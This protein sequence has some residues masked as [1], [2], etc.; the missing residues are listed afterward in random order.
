MGGSAKRRIGG[1]AI[2][3]LVIAGVVAVTSPSASG[4]TAPEA[5]GPVL[6]DYGTLTIGLNNATGQYKVV[7]DPTAAAANVE[8]V[9][10]ATQPCATVTPGVGS[11]L[12]F[13]PNQGSLSDTVQIRNNAF[14]VNTGNTSC[15][16]SAAAV[17]SG[18]ELLKI[19][20]GSALTG[21][22]APVQ[23][24]AKSAALNLTRV[25]TGNLTLGF[26]GGSQGSSIPFSGTVNVTPAEITTADDLFTSITIGSTSTKAGEG[27]SVA[28]GTSFELVTLDP[29]FEVA[30]D[31]GEQVTQLGATAT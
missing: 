17:I 19:D 5:S 14:G 18:S 22:A 4:G 25:K 27:L 30:V 24:F 16:S 10:G 26:N 29:D 13:T 2:T 6:T 3:G 28:T 21:S 11:L 8:Q 23:V 9:I 31:C 7:L 12:K 1:L 20:L 15:G